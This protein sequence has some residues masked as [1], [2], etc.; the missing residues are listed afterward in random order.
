MTRSGTLAA[1]LALALTWGSSFLLMKV[2]L[3]GLAPAQVVL[4]RLG[5]GALTLCALMAATRR[6]WP[7]EP[8]LWVH[9]GVVAV[10]L[11]VVPFLLFAWAG[12]HLPSGL[13]SILNATTPIMTVAVGALALPTERLTLPQLSGILLGAAGVAVVMGV[14]TVVADPA[15][16]ASVPAQLACLGATAC[17]GIAF[18]YL[19]RFVVGT[20]QHDALTISAVQIVLGAAAIGLAAPAV[21]TAP[22][23]LTAPVVASIVALGA[24]GTGIAYIWNTAVAMRWG[25]TI[26]STV[27]Y[28]TPLVGVVLGAVVLHERLAWY[29]PVGGVLVVAGILVAQ[30]GTGRSATA[31][32]GVG[33][34]VVT[35]PPGLRRPRP[36]RR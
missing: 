32:R 33:P 26:A 3:D 7:R 24:L 2:A 35:T 22:V 11:C 9:L 29:Q 25:P 28:L 30:H 13:S 1:Y 31:G 15:F 12:Q 14:W 4:G 18:T 5:I 10:F 21:A 8:R 20:H 34:A 19:R 17:Y 23:D 16:A 36:P 6:P 27:T